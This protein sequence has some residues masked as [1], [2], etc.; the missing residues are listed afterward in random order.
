M[1][2]FTRPAV[3]RRWGFLSVFDNF[4]AVEVVEHV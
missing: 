2:F 1:I 3:A 4:F